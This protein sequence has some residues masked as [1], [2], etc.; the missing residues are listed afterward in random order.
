MSRTHCVSNVDI[1]YKLP[2]GVDH[3]YSFLLNVNVRNSSKWSLGCCCRMSFKHIV[4]LLRQGHCCIQCTQPL[5]HQCPCCRH[6]LLH[7]A[8]L[9]EWLSLLPD[10]TEECAD[11]HK[12]SHLSLIALFLQLV[13]FNMTLEL[14]FISNINSNEQ[15]W[16]HQSDTTNQSFSSN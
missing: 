12:C 10:A 16:V 8:I 5:A 11:F 6:Q 1:K 7:T 2:V 15:C 13:F 9:T 14:S 3:D 4:R